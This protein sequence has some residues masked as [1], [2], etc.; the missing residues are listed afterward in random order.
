MSKPFKSFK[1]PF[2]RI[3]PNKNLSLCEGFDVKVVDGKLLVIKCI[4]CGEQR[5]LEIEK[6]VPEL[7]MDILVDC[8]ETHSCNG[9]KPIH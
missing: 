1:S 5:Q 9:N 3:I 6:E 4:S 8:Y 2:N 7:I